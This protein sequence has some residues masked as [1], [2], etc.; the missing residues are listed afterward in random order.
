MQSKFT[1]VENNVDKSISE[2]N[3]LANDVEQKMQQ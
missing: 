2:W 3:P 1:T